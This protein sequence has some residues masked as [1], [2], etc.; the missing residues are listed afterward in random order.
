MGAGAH[1]EIVLPRVDGVHLLFLQYD[2]KSAQCWRTRHCLGSRPSPPTCQRSGVVIPSSRR[3]ALQPRFSWQTRAPWP[4]PYTAW[5]QLTFPSVQWPSTLR[6]TAAPAHP[7]DLPPWFWPRS[8][9]LFRTRA[10][11]LWK[12]PFIK[13]ASASIMYYAGYR[14]LIQMVPINGQSLSMGPLKRCV[15]WCFAIFRVIAFFWLQLLRYVSGSYKG[16]YIYTN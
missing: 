4:C 8:R 15:I 3:T 11:F 14:P 13:K 12:Q 10:P 6:I 2:L 5:Q 16:V 1:S 7:R 9:G